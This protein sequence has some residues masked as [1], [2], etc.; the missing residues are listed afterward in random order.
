MTSVVES[1]RWTTLATRI[2]APNPGP[3]SLDGTNTYV[4]R[5]PGST[6]AVVVD[7][8]PEIP[9][10]LDRIEQLGPIG[11]ILLT[12]H[13]SDH[14]E[15]IA[16]MAVRTGAPVRAVDST[17]CIGSAPLRDGETIVAGGT[18]IIVFATPGHTA[19]SVCFQLPEDSTIGADE[20]MGSMLTGDTILG[21][22]TT[23]LAQPNGALRDYLQS[24]ETL[25]D[26][27]GVQT[28]LPG[29]GPLL[30]SL[31]SIAA[32][33]LAHRRLRLAQVEDALAGL[34]IAAS[35]DAG[36]VTRVTDIVYPQIDADI[37]FAAEA[38][39]AAQLEY[40]AGD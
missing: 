16:T 13:H 15:S 11:L 24:L 33:Y 26:L 28:A 5:A 7:P 1:E 18:R 12:H 4:I 22:G 9:S 10:H 17:L 20:R 21:R 29:H 3:M 2:L 30:P 37:R 25:R 32:S 31:S 40:L 38:S 19:D 6:S 39:T 8:G 23:I 14:A 35:R 34:G 27:V 36:V